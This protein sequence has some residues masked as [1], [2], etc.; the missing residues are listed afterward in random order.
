[1]DRLT[2]LL[3]IRISLVTQ[4]R[5]QRVIHQMDEQHAQ[6]LETQRLIRELRDEMH[7]HWDQLLQRQDA[8]FQNTH[9]H[10]EELL[11]SQTA[12]SQNTQTQLAMIIERQNQILQIEPQLQE[13]MDRLKAET[14]EQMQELRQL[15]II[16][17]T[18]H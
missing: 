13:R 15:C 8:M 10:W 12:F 9:T 4:A 3:S 2:L 6:M 7:L 11:Q 1:M 18:H 5:L 14:E 17:L 16:Q